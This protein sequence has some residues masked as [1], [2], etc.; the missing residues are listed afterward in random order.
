MNKTVEEIWFF[1]QWLGE[2]WRKQGNDEQI[3][4]YDPN[5]CLTIPPLTH[6]QYRN[7]RDESLVIL[8]VT[9]PP[10]PGIYGSVDVEG[11]WS[12]D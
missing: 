5:T 8:V 2:F 4:T 9:M 3:V 7:V 11:K 10:F 6:F 12:V 1:I